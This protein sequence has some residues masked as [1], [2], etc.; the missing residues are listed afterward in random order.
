MLKK[1]IQKL[2]GY[3][4]ENS[5]ITTEKSFVGCS[6]LAE[7]KRAQVE[8]VSRSAVLGAPPAACTH[9]SGGLNEAKQSG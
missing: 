2:K 4:V 8:T 9:L 5:I 1:I 3:K 7:H 6:E